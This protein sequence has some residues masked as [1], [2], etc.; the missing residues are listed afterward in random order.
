MYMQ[1]QLYLAIVTL[2][3]LILS[4][5]CSSMSDV[6]EE[7]PAQEAA[8]EPV[9]AQESVQVE[10]EPKKEELQTTF[11]FDFDEATV[12]PS[13]V[14]VIEAHAERIKTSAEVVRIEGYADDRGTEIYNKELGQRRADA[15]RD[16]LISMGVNSSQIETVSFGEQSPQA[17]GSGEFIWQQNRRVVLK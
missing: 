12:R 3:T 6:V 13:A 8:P 1:K 7:S 14:P 17:S 15:V 2:F 9:A 11:Y 4:A 5:G 10:P 16:L